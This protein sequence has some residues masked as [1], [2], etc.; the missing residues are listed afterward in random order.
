MAIPV[1]LDVDTGVDDALALILALRSPELEVRAVTTVAGNT[2]V[3]NATAN[4]L[5]VL[6]LLEAREDLP[7]GQGAAGPRARELETAAEV[8]GTDG[9]GNVRALY[10]ASRRKTASLSAEELLLETIR[11]HPGEL[12]LIATGPM[13]NLAVALA[14]DPATFRQL[15]GIIQMGGAVAVP[16]NTS[17]HAE[18]NLFVDPEAATQVF[19]S[20]VPLPPGQQRD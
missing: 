12:T 18:F 16:G 20:G 10:P 8:H 3:A 6:D 14:R 5:L 9:L 7:V 1:V 17:P 15:K 4:T 11:Q 13:T 2:T 19:E